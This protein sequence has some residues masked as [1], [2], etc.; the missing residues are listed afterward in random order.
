MNL[1]PF[2]IQHF[3]R[4]QE[5]FSTMSTPQTDTEQAF[6]EWL[7]HLTDEIADNAIPK[8]RMYGTAELSHLGATLHQVRNTATP[9]PPATDRRNLQDALWFYTAGKL[10]RWTA[11]VRREEQPSRD[12]VYDILVYSLMWL[13]V[14]ETGEWWP[15]HEDDNDTNQHLTPVSESTEYPS[16]VDDFPLGT[17]LRETIPSDEDTLPRVYVKMGLNRWS[18]IDAQG[19]V[20]VT[21]DM[22]KASYLPNRSRFEVLS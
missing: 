15:D 22:F 16:T 6:R 10:A 9:T 5:T 7:R 13:K 14:E 3:I 2:G 11:A 21:S 1:F 8:A 12:T 17:I 20:V 18:V 19:H 4:R